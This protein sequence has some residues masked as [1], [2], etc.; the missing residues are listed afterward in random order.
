MELSS[1]NLIV[2]EKR[3]YAFAT[4]FENLMICNI[5]NSLFHREEALPPLITY[6]FKEDTVN[7]PL[8][9]EQAMLRLEQFGPNTTD[10]KKESKWYFILLRA[11][12]HPFN[13]LLTVLAIIAGATGDFIT[14]VF[15]AA[16]VVLS[17][18]LR[19]V[20]GTYFSHHTCC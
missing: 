11:I 12:V 19:F 2:E 1:L 10:Q 14:V 13:I 3:K 16:M 18:G 4:T 9:W 7:K 17:T 5:F 15:M 8:T 20:Q 6:P